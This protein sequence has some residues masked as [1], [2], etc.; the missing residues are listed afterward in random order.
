MKEELPILRATY[1]HRLRELQERIAAGC[2][3]R[4]GPGSES[5]P[6]K[7]RQTPDADAPQ[8]PK[9]PPNILR[10]LFALINKRI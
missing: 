8:P 5:G 1:D 4:R 6:E 10:R 7:E 9:I 2:S 3:Q